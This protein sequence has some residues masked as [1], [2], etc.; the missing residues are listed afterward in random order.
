MNTKK[1]TNFLKRLATAVTLIVCGMSL[2]AACSGSDG[3]AEPC[4]TCG[5]DPAESG[6]LRVVNSAAHACEALVEA[7]DGRVVSVD[8]AGATVGRMV[9]QGDRA[10]ISVISDGT[11][12][13]PSIAG[14]IRFSGELKLLSHA[15]YGRNGDVLVGEGLTL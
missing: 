6:A 11:A 8:F 5:D 13:L 15:C 7:T 12:A 2:L 4:T 1:T 10:G 9:R 14:A 3:S